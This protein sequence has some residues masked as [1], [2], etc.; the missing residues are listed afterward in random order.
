MDENLYRKLYE[1]LGNFSK[2]LQQEMNLGEFPTMEMDRQMIFY[3]I[4]EI[5][6]YLQDMKRVMDVHE[7]PDTI[8]AE[9]RKK[10]GEINGLDSKPVIVSE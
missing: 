1:A 9:F 4:R 10:K 3:K 5:G 2:I 8:H 6:G 7:N